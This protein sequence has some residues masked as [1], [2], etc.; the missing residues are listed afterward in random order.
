MLTAE[1]ARDVGGKGANQA[2]AAARSGVEVNLCAV[3]GDDDHGR[4]IKAQLEAEGVNVR[5]VRTVAGPT[6]ESI[7]YVTP[8]G[9]NSI[10]STY[11]A[12]RSMRQND[13][14]DSLL[15]ATTSDVVLMQ[16][17][18]P[19]DLTLL[20]LQQARRTGAAT[21]LNPAP[22]NY[23][24]DDI[25]PFVDHAILNEVEVESLTGHVDAE[26]GA[27]SLMDRGVGRVVVTLGAAGAVTVSRDVVDEIS[28]ESVQAVDATGAGDVFCGIYAAGLALSKPLLTTATAAVGAATLS[29]T[30]PGTQS[31]FPTRAELDGIMAQAQAS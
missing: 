2:V 14:T 12:A 6:D 7:I 26:K 20:A 3:V 21:V 22:V 23:E 4:M 29:V 25:W 9:E 11:A 31:A 10:V 24:F 1:H 15:D 16:G 13:V 5:H 17:N 28:A 19:R 27:R 18:L 30:R 8:D